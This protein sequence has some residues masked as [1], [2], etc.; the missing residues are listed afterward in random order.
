[1]TFDSL[2]EHTPSA[3]DLSALSWVH[4]EL[5]RT[6]D[7]AHKSLRRHLRE[8]DSI[9]GSDLGA[10]DPAVLRQARNQL[11]QAAGALELIG[12]RAGA[13]LLQASEAAVQRAVGKPSLLDLPAV[14]TIERASFALL[15]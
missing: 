1:M 5:R 13:S 11:H 4:E 12:L 8:S 9:H 7:A 3:D 15:D 2:P 6:L 14:E 10:V